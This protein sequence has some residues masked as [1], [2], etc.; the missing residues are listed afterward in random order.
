M[1][2][3]V[4]SSSVEAALIKG[5]LSS[6]SPDQSLS[7]YKN[8]CESVGLNPLTKPFEYMVLNNK[9]VLYANKGCAEQLRSLHKISIKIVD[10]IKIDDVYIVTA[11]A[12]NKDGRVDSSTGAVSVVGLKGEALAN[13]LMKAETKAKRRVT[14]SVCGLNMLDETEVETIPAH[15]K[16]VKAAEVPA[17]EVIE[18]SPGHYKITF[19]KFRGQTIEDVNMFELNDY[20]RYIEKKANEDGKEIK[21]Q[22]LE[23][24]QAAKSFLDSRDTSLDEALR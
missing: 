3:I 15:A 19:G 10:K 12:E 22:V 11:E 16:L 24:L 5:D 23:F 18:F 8:V 1:S 6:L 20:A 21:G 14:L 17:S 7:Y 2:N 13:A 9:K 4:S